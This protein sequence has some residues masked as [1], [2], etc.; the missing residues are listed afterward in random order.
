M[1]TNYIIY[2]EVKHKDKWYCINNKIINVKENKAQLSTTYWSGSRS[3]FGETYNKLESIGKSINKK[4]LSYELKE[5][6]GEETDANEI[7]PIAVDYEKMKNCVPADKFFENYGYVNKN[8]IARYKLGDIDDIYDWI[9]I[10]E[11]EKLDSKEKQMYEYFEWDN[12][13][14]WLVY[15]KEIIEHVKWQIM[16]WE[17]INIGNDIDKIRLIVFLF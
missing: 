17:D 15:F 6:H 4:E 2:T 5:I 12:S 16:E 8:I 9:D 3:Y 1:S 7:L 11:Y 13:E 14:G 10:Y